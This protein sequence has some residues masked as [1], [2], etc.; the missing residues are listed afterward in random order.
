MVYVWYT[1]PSLEMMMSLDFQIFF[2]ASSWLCP[3][4]SKV[5]LTQILWLTMRSRSC[6]T[7]MMFPSMRDMGSM[8][9]TS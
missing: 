7:P 3:S 5:M 2:S 8:E 4:T 9:P 6:M 1:E